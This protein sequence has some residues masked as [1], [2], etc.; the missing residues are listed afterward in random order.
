MKSWRRRLALESHMPVSI[1]LSLLFE[2]HCYCELDLAAL[3]T[4]PNY[5]RQGAGSMLLDWGLERADDNGL[6]A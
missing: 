6:A 4:S 2:H 1:A 5:Q 3:G